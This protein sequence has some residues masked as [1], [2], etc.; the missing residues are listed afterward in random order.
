[1][2]KVV[3]GHFKFEVIK[4]VVMIDVIKPKMG[5]GGILFEEDEVTPIMEVVQEPTEIDVRQR[6][7]VKQQE[8]DLNP[9]ELAQRDK[10]QVK[11]NS[12]RAKEDHA[13]L[14]ERRDTLKAKAIAKANHDIMLASDDASV[15]AKY[16]LDVEKIEAATTIDALEAIII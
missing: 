13:K 16:R 11:H 8:V 9:E 2:K 12:N 10:D 7:W 5:N 14:E 1:M 3:A 15:K 4:Q 6:V